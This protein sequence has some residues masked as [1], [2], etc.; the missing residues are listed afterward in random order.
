MI[1]TGEKLKSKGSI[2]AFKNI[3]KAVVWCITNNEWS[4]NFLSN[5]DGK[6]RMGLLPIGE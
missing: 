5:R 4:M 3:E 6:I 2:L 1:R